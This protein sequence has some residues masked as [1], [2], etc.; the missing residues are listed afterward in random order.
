MGPIQATL[1]EKGGFQGHGAAPATKWGIW[2][3]AIPGVMGHGPI[4]DGAFC[5][6]GE[7]RAGWSVREGR[8]M[9]ATARPACGE[10]R[11]CLIKGDSRVT[12]YEARDFQRCRVCHTRVEPVS[13][14]NV[15]SGT[16]RKAS[17]PVQWLDGREYPW[18]DSP[19]R[20]ARDP[21]FR[22]AGFSVSVLTLWTCTGIGTWRAQVDGR[23]FVA[24]MGGAA[25]LQLNDSKH[26][27][28]RAGSGGG[29]HRPCCKGAL[30]TPGESGPADK[31]PIGKVH[32]APG[33]HEHG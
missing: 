28:S 32:F 17:P 8:E 23:G 9:A 31:A 33:R 4:G 29:V 18:P 14:T 25:P 3:M 13:E 21:P 12:P 19:E 24:E 15:G 27:E 6:T 20:G 1:F 16:G 11:G 22:G 7:R 26:L 10:R 2:N 30:C 5:P